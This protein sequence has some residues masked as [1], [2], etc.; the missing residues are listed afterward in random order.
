MGPQERG[1]APGKALLTMGDAAYALACGRTRVYELVQRG[2]IVAVGKGKSRRVT[3]ASVREYV[4][5]LVAKEVAAR[6][7]EVSA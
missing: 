4:A 3:A 5:G 1:L 2:E 6:R 7:L